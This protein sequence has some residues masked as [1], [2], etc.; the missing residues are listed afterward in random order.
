MP[1]IYEMKGK[2]FGRLTVINRAVSCGRDARW[3]CQCTCGNI[4]T[5]RGYSLRRGDTKSCGCFYRELSHKKNRARTIRRSRYNALDKID[6]DI[7]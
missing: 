5:V 2:V 7:L 4:T 3:N 1:R 6:P